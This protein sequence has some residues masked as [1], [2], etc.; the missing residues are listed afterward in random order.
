MQSVHFTLCSSQL[1]GLSVVLFTE[2]AQS[3]LVAG[4]RTLQGC[5]CAALIHTWVT[6][7]TVTC[8]I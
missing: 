3:L 5:H 2:R 6:E 1:Y 8:H 7:S 4:Q